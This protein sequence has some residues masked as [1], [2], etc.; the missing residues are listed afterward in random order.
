MQ[1]K[2]NACCSLKPPEI[3]LL[4]RRSRKLSAF[5]LMHFQL[6]LLNLDFYISQ[7]RAKVLFELFVLLLK[8]KGTGIKYLSSSYLSGNIGGAAQQTSKKPFSHRRKRRRESDGEGLYTS[9]SGL[10]SR[11]SSGESSNKLQQTQIRG[12]RKQRSAQEPTYSQ[13]AH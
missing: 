9:A 6:L 2:K 1:N 10:F 3:R 7:G 13:K 5:T 12:N 8:H 4:K 11:L